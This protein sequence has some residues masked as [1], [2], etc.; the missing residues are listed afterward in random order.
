[1]TWQTDWLDCYV[2][3]SMEFNRCT[4]LY[5]TPL[6]EAERWLFSVMCSCCWLVGVAGSR[7]GRTLFRIGSRVDFV[8]IF[9]IVNS[10]I[11]QILW[12]VC[13][14][15]MNMKCWHCA[16]HVHAIDLQISLLFGSFDWSKWKLVCVNCNP[17][18]I[19]M[20]YNRYLSGIGLTLWCYL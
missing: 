6:A 8:S 2:R 18:Y 15:L 9:C 17:C 12:C 13:L 4:T 7:C 19:V 16:G 5:F 3:S 10:T 1:M 14:L 20:P 11:F